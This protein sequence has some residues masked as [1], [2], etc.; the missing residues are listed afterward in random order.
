M[1]KILKTTFSLSAPHVVFMDGGVQ[2]ST[3]DFREFDDI[4]YH[5]TTQVVAFHVNLWEYR[6]IRISLRTCDNPDQTGRDILDH[7]AKVKMK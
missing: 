6:D 2:L 3:I 4:S 5:S 7:W 1:L